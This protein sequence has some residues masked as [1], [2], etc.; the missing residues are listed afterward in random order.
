MA[1][2]TIDPV[3]AEKLRPKASK[4][5]DQVMHAALKS[6]LSPEA[7]QRVV[8]QGGELQKL[9]TPIIIRLSGETVQTVPVSI[10]GSPRSIDVLG[11]EGFSAEMYFG[12]LTG[13]IIDYISPSFKD[14]IAGC[15]GQW[16][17]LE[18]AALRCYQVEKLTETQLIIEAV[19]DRAFESFLEA[20][21][22][23]WQMIKA[24]GRG[25][26][27]NL[28]TIG[29]RSN[30]FPYPKGAIFCRWSKSERGWIVTDRLVASPL[31][32]DVYDQVFSR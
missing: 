32:W 4:I 2:E 17:N 30:I 5:G 14:Q 15:H 19:G 31:A 18:A 8:E 12:S 28:A 23:M 3:L 13:V 27:G 20:S 25:Q 29:F 16:I 26:C 7:L 10:L 24:Q 6:G 21:A 1:R 11:A 9:V 22:R